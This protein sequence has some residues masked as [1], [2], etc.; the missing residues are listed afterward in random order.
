[1]ILKSAIVLTFLGL[2]Y[3]V[4]AASLNAEGNEVATNARKSEV[5]QLQSL[6][7]R[8][9]L[10][11]VALRSQLKYVTSIFKTILTF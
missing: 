2:V 1:M 6:L 9:I 5:E 11:N 7:A 10:E 8:E 4:S 3:H